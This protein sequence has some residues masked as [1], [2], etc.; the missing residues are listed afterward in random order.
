MFSF[1]KSF[2]FKNKDAFVF[3]NKVQWRAELLR[4]MDSDTEAMH[5]ELWSQ[6]IS[7]P[8]L[9]QHHYLKSNISDR[10]PAY[11]E[12]L[13]KA[14]EFS[15]FMNFMN[16]AFNLFFRYEVHEIDWLLAFPAL[17]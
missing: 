13:Q 7:A 6:A 4:F 17:L 15:N 9:K 10:S 3:K 1:F 14:A 11:Y 8:T 12:L 2:I 5:L 16:F